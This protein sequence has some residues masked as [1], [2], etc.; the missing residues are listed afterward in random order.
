[1]MA[2]GLVW[3]GLGFVATRELP[4]PR[5]DDLAAPVTGVPAVV[6]GAIMIAA[7]LYSLLPGRRAEN[8]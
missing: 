8:R 4:V 1:M 3:V 2:L 7:G 5:N 6:A